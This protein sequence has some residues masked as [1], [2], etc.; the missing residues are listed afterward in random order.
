MNIVVKPSIRM[1]MVHNEEEVIMM[2]M[3]V[4]GIAKVDE[5]GYD[6][7]LSMGIKSALVRFSPES[8]WDQTDQAGA[9]IESDPML[10]PRFFVYM[11][12]LEIGSAKWAVYGLKGGA[13]NWWESS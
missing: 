6:K 8:A 1:S 3:E 13:L 10:I 9:G 7:R 12:I 5:F 11:E 2:G 4:G